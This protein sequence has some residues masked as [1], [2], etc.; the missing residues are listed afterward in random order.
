M[1][2]QRIR[3]SSG[4]LR[5]EWTR[6]FSVASYPFIVLQTEFSVTTLPSCTASTSIFCGNPSGPGRAGLPMSVS[7]QTTGHH[8]GVPVTNPYSHRYRRRSSMPSASALPMPL[9]PPNLAFGD[10]QVTGMHISRDIPFTSQLKVNRSLFT[11]RSRRRS[12]PAQRRPDSVHHRRRACDMR[13]RRSHCV[14]LIPLSALR[15]HIF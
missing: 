3:S 12:P 9:D 1:S 14:P 15:C 5:A 2:S 10:F 6:V 4:F 11:R 13:D 8:I 7:L